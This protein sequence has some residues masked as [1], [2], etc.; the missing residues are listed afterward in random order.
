MVWTIQF[1]TESVDILAVDP[2]TSPPLTTEITHSLVI[3]RFSHA[4]DYA[5]R[6][7][8]TAL[9]YLGSMESVPLT[10]DWTPNGSINVDYPTGLS[11]LNPV[12][13]VSPA[14]TPIEVAPVEFPYDAPTLDDLQI[15]P[16]TVPEFNIPL[17][18]FI[19]PSP[20]TT[21]V[22][23]LT[24]A[25][26]PEESIILPSPGD[27]PALPPL[28][29]LTE[30]LPPDEP[31]FNIP[32]F[33]AILPVEDLTAPELVYSWNEAAYS[34]EVLEALRIK[35]RDGIIN[36]GVGML[37][38]VEQAI[39][40]RAATR[41]NVELQKTENIAWNDAAS[42]GTRIPQG[43]LIAR[44]QEIYLQNALAREDLTRDVMI[45]SADLAYQYSTFVIDKGIALEHELM[46]LFNGV[47][48]RAFEASK[49]L[50]DFA[51]R[52][53]EVR[54]RAYI[55]RLEAYKTEAEVFRARIQAEIARADLYKSIIEG[56]KLSLEMQAL[57]VDLYGKQIASIETMARIYGI[58]MEGAKVQAQIYG[59]R[60][61]QFKA[62][63]EAYKAQ[64]EGVTAEY[65][66]YTAQ[67]TGESEKAKMYSYQVQGY[68]S[69]VD[70]YKSRSEVDVN[71]LQLVIDKNKAE[72]GIFTARLDKYRAE[73]QANVSEAEIQAK[74][75]GLKLQA[76][77]GEIRKFTSIVSAITDSYKAQADIGIANA[78][79]NIKYGDMLA[80]LEIAAAQIQAELIRA[81]GLVASQLAASALSSVSAG[82][83]LGY[84]QSRSDQGSTSA[85]NVRSESSQSSTS[86]SQNV[87]SSFQNYWTNCC[88]GND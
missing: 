86:H 69:L 22:P 8:S 30:I 46:D 57:M 68:A 2:I 20:P 77:D 3:D 66:L 53:Y 87:Q 29:I 81:K 74:A 75:E 15:V 59:V 67:I 60:I 62:L 42:R 38:E 24:A 78:E 61:D 50:V 34:S 84:S 63:V 26:P 72:V 71:N 27:I 6:A 51:I 47:Q 52:A 16:V 80:R 85:Q 65:G 88:D 39:Y 79:V 76:F 70:A 9:T 17:P 28:P 11:G 21:P 33:T 64:V 55:A 18:N 54:V 41:L 19:I 35:L 5:D 56:R 25:P 4:Q 31:T 36:G 44:L 12:E 40:D 37:P 10:F 14:I 83:S 23:V 48:Q 1:P 13:P 7:Y 45:K 43:A 49:V 58:K 82:A 32:E 73:I